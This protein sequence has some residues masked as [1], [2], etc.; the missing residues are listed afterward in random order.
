[1]SLHACYL[2][3]P[4][5]YQCCCNCAFRLTDYKH[6]TTVPGG[7][8]NGCVCDEVKGYICSGTGRHHSGWPEHSAGCELYTAL[9]KP[10][11]QAI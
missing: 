3:E 2:N 1:M 5:F 8:A 11:D 10:R 4:P 9:E 6:C 7:N